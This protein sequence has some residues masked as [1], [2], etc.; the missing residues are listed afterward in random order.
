MRNVSNCCE[1]TIKINSKHCAKCHEP[2]EI[3]T[4]YDNP[5]YEYVTSEK[6]NKRNKNERYKSN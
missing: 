5:N 4:F 2:C 1:A 3:V 6:I